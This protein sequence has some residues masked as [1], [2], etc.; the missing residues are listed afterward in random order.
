M[1]TNRWNNYRKA[2]DKFPEVRRNEL[3]LMLTKVNPKK[4]EIIVEAGT[5]NG[6]LTFPIAQKVGKDGKVITY[7]II[8]E[9]LAEVKDLNKKFKLPIEIRQQKTSYDF[10]E[11]DSSV[12]KVVSIASFHHYDDKSKKTGFSGRL[13]ALKEFARILKKNGKLIIGDV[14]KNTVSH[15]YFD[16]IDT[17]KYCFPN[18]H[19]HDFLSKKEIQDLCSQ[20]GFTIEAYEVVHVPWTFESE[21]QAKE[22]LHTI[23]NASCSPEESFEHAKKYLNFWKEND[24]Y[25]L[26]WELFYLVAVK[27]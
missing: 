4:G 11:Q 19:P 3:Q 17:P 18:G 13:R 27:K 10:E 2:N 6:Y 22:F 24:L 23:H 12:D 5:G 25:Y 14:G 20:A 16:A 26:D 15:K 7:D 21:E 8:P 9:N 1:E